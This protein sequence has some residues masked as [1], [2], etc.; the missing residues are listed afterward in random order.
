MKLKENFV[1]RQISG[2]W[3]VLPLGVET[4]D[5]SGMLKLNETGAMLWNLL[6]DGCGE[7]DLV[8]ALTAEYEV[9]TE[10]AG[11]DVE[12]YLAKLRDAGCLAD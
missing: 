8:R 4:V 10:Q 1:L 2:P 5:F 9:S 11:A 6:K 7:D 3:I 12:E